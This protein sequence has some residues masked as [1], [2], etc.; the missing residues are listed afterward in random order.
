MQLGDSEVQDLKGINTIC[1]AL[2]SF[3]QNLSLEDFFSQG[4]VYDVLGTF[5]IIIILYLTFAV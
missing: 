2:H 5:P 4:T 1:L 3:S